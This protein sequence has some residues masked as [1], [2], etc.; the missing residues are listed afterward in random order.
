MFFVFLPKAFI[1]VIVKSYNKYYYQTNHGGGEDM[2][3][4]ENLWLVDDE[5]KKLL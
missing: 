5:P 2:Y 1:I 4:L 3:T